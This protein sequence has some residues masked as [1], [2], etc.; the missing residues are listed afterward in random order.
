MWC[1]WRCHHWC[2]RG[3]RWLHTLFVLLLLVRNACQFFEQSYVGRGWFSLC[4]IRRFRTKALV[5]I[6]FGTR[7]VILIAT[8]IR[9][10]SSII[11]VPIVRGLGRFVTD[12]LPIERK[13]CVVEA[14]CHFSM[15]STTTAAASASIILR[16]VQCSRSIAF[17]SFLPCCILSRI[18]WILLAAPRFVVV[19]LLADV[20]FFCFGRFVALV[21]VGA[22]A[23]AAAATTAVTHTTAMPIIV[24][25]VPFHCNDVVATIAATLFECEKRLSFLNGPNTTRRFRSIEWEMNFRGERCRVRCRTLLR[26]LFTLIQIDV[27]YRMMLDVAN[28]DI[29]PSC[30]MEGPKKSRRPNCETIKLV[31]WYF[32]RLNGKCCREHSNKHIHCCCDAIHG[33][34]I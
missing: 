10:I 31:N 34:M 4:R 26:P 33:Q 13:H 22:T 32:I 3:G 27:I 9:Q 17:V 25:T 30:A 7:C 19:V 5:V 6:V 29:R 28:D 24:D 12:G 14:F 15:S 18:L 2:G 20:I 1:L 23:T 8:E 21:V 16:F 11:F